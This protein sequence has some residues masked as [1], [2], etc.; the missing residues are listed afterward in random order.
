[1]ALYTQKGR[2]NPDG[3]HTLAAGACAAAAFQ[4]VCNPRLRSRA[5]RALD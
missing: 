3:D 4:T 1:M 2:N 5:L